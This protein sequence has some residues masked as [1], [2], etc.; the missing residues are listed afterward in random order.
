MKLM[1]SKFKF[2][3]LVILA[4]FLGVLGLWVDQNYIQQ[5]TLISVTGEGKVLAKPE[6]VQFTVSLINTASSAASVV[7]DN[8][9]L[10]KNVLLVLKVGGVEEKDLNVAYP[11]VIPPGSTYGQ[12]QYQAVNTVDAT[13]NNINNFDAL[14]EQIYNQGGQTISNIVFTTKN[15]KDLEKQA[16]GKA[17]EDAKNRV[18]ELAKTTGKR[19]GRMVSIATSEVGTSG[20]LSGQAP[21]SGTT[22]SPTVT[23]TSPTQ[24]EIFRQ[25]S[26]VFELR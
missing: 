21:T 13:L 12:T 26:I 7:S 22:A 15:A 11:R 20:A 4:F 14:A 1:E 18:Q 17:I 8:V 6:M 3:G 2:G 16:V 23:S 9:R 24:I 19:V 5:P 25:A 10:T